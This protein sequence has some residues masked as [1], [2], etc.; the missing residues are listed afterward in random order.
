MIPGGFAAPGGPG[1]LP[2]R[3]WKEE[4]VWGNPQHGFKRRKNRFRVEVFLAP[5]DTGAWGNPLQ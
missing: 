3:C 1:V 4:G 2:G 5:T